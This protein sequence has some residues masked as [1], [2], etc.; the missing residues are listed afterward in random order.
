MTDAIARIKA[1]PPLP[2]VP[3]IVLSSDK[4]PPP[5]VLKPD[6][7]TLAQI[8]QANG[9]LAAALGTIDIVSN[10]SGHNMMLYQPKFVADNIVAIVDRVRQAG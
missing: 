4:F 1:A 3:A 7:Y 5:E 10:G 8:H 9:M 6:N 2:R